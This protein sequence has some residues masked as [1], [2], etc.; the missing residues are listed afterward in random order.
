MT[1][2]K[3]IIAACLFGT[4]S[5]SGCALTTN[6]KQPE[7]NQAVSDCTKCVSGESGQ[8][9]W[10]EHCSKGFVKGEVISCENCYKSIANNNGPC[11]KD[12]CEGSD[13]V[14][15]CMACVQGEPCQSCLSVRSEELLGDR[16]CGNCCGNG[17]E[18]K[19]A[20]CTECLNAEPCE[21]CE[22]AKSDGMSGVGCC[23]NCESN[24][25]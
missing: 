21:D 1:L 3:N 24:D 9:L 20:E 4:I 14:A 23:P 11:C 15:Q 7:V 12:C 25:A 6:D 10:C 22:Q 19:S 2:T 5:V 18:D 8:T 13:K 16:Q 17:S